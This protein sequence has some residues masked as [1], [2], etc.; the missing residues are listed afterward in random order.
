MIKQAFDMWD[1]AMIATL[2][3]AEETA[4]ELEEAKEYLEKSVKN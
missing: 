2:T 3:K 4:R 1:K